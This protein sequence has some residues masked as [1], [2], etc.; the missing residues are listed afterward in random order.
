MIIP[1]N[2]KLPASTYLPVS[3][4]EA[5]LTR[6]D[7]YD[8]GRQAWILTDHVHADAA[9]DLSG[10][11]DVWTCGADIRTCE[12][13]VAALCERDHAHDAELDGR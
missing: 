13:Y 5:A 10:N 8:Y 4:I 2:A 3:E 11:W 6:E 1:R 7:T 12:P 9:R